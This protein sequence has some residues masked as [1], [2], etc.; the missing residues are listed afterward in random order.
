MRAT[1]DAFVCLVS[2][3]LAGQA[4][5]GSANSVIE[6]PKVMVHRADAAAHPGWT[7]YSNDPLRLSGAD[8][9][10]IVDSHLE[11]TLDPDEV[12]RLNDENQTEVSVFRV[13]KHRREGPFTLLCEYGDHAQ[14]SRLLPEQVKE[15][16]VVRRKSFGEEGAV[17]VKCV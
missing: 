12:R 5:A 2:A 10:Y 8:F 6:C 4:I 11:A 14:L 13:S 3:A 16:T 15:C 9:M 1:K 7:I 17:E